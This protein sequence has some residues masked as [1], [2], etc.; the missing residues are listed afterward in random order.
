MTNARISF[1]TTRSISP[2]LRNDALIAPI[3][4]SETYVLRNKG[5][6]KMSIIPKLEKELRPPEVQ[7]LGQTGKI[8]QTGQ[9]EQA[10]QTGQTPQTQHQTSTSQQTQV[11]QVNKVR[12]KATAGFV[13]G[14]EPKVIFAQ[15]NN[16]TS[17]SGM[18]KLPNVEQLLLDENKIRNF[19]GL[20]TLKNL[21][22]LSLA[23]NNITSFK[24]AVHLPN[25][26]VLNMS[27]NPIADYVPEGAHKLSDKAY[28]LMAFVAFGAQKLTKIDGD[29]LTLFERDDGD[30]LCDYIQ[31]LLKEGFVLR[32][33]F[34][35]P[36]NTRE[37]ALGIYSAQFIQNEDS[38]REDDEDEQSG[39]ENDS[40]KSK[41]SLD[42]DQQYSLRRKERLRER[43][44]R[45]ERG[46]RWEQQQEQ[47]Y[48]QSRITE[49]HQSSVWGTEYSTHSTSDRISPELN[50]QQPYQKSDADKDQPATKKESKSVKDNR[51]D[52]LSSN[53]ENKQKLQSS[54]QST[55]EREIAQDKQVGRSAHIQTQQQT[56]KDQ[57]T[58]KTENDKNEEDDQKDAQIQEQAMK[59]MLK[60][61]KGFIDLTWHKNKKSGSNF[62]PSSART[63]YHAR[64]R[65]NRP[66]PF[67][68]YDPNV[69]PDYQIPGSPSKDKK[70]EDVSGDEN[71]EK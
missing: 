50:S 6:S 22:Y 56:Q 17:F 48:T 33:I 35:E 60:S 57:Q 5:L 14:T 4:A 24:G 64:G 2:K 47:P 26:E 19:Y 3:V 67:I 27:G 58:N 16:F 8:S 54:Q 71:E 1:T 32:H 13:K 34:N 25:L 23:D 55:N 30:R 29:T 66:S 63:P 18:P 20:H 45:L 69:H 41:E 10:E 42:S 21:R 43:Q 53:Q 11:S 52:A 38:N 62:L 68:I 46:Q 9:Q 28:R 12:S 70:K 7:Q 40:M 59:K 31:D 36:R 37:R 39:D 65:Y 51:N 15:Q 49:V 44:E 61:I